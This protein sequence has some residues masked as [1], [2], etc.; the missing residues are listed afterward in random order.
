M[1]VRF[2]K[3]DDLLEAVSQ[4]LISVNFRQIGDTPFSSRVKWI[5]STTDI[6][7]IRS[8]HSAGATFRDAARLKDGDESFSLIYPVNS[9]LTLSHLGNE[10]RLLSGQPLFTRHDA[11]CEMGAASN[12]DFVALVMSPSVARAARLTDAG[13]IAERVPHNFPALKLLKDYIAVLAAR[14]EMLPPQMASSVAHHLGELLR[15]VIG[16]AT[17]RSPESDPTS[18]ATARLEVALAFLR[19]EFRSP[20]LNVAAVAA[21]QAVSPRYLHRLFER[22]GLR[23]TELVNELRLN[24]AYAALAKKDEKSVTTI[25]LETGFSDIAHFNRLFKKRFGVTPGAVRSRKV[26]N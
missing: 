22:A 1:E 18:I 17:D 3:I 6:S 4:R 8:R 12:C 7:I 11:V 15:L 24:A 10:R 21:D 26:E 5:V 16:E 13:I 25:A 20:E 9:S 19:R 14:H 23:F 2:D